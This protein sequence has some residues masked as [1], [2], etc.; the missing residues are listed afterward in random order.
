MVGHLVILI[1]L[2]VICTSIFLDIIFKRRIGNFIQKAEDLT[3]LYDSVRRSLESGAKSVSYDGLYYS[4][5]VNNGDYKS[6]ILQVDSI[7]TDIINTYENIGNFFLYQMYDEDAEFVER[8]YQRVIE[9]KNEIRLI[10]WRN[11]YEQT[12]SV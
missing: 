3:I 5:S 8:L 1:L 7:V 9:I 10:K 12:K 11:G 2:F 6:F 4:L